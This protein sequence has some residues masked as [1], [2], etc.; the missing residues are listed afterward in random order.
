MA[1]RTTGLSC[2][3][4]GRVVL[5]DVNIAVPQGRITCVLG[6]SGC[7]KSTLLKTL[8]MLEPAMGGSIYIGADDMCCCDNARLQVLRRSVGVLFQG[9]ALFNS[10]TLLENVAFP[11]LELTELDEAIATETARLKLAL[12][13]LAPYAHFLPAEV[14]G[15]MRKRCGIAR[16]LVR[17]PA[18]LFLDEPGAGLDPTTSAGLD[19]MILGIRNRLGTTIVVVTHELPSIHAIADHCIMLAGGRVIAQGTLEQVGASGAPGVREFFERI[20]PD[21]PQPT[22]GLATLLLP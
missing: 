8:L 15:G 9:A 4:D 14:S 11:L 17:D 7:G 1:I 3:Y 12:V 6:G 22:E 13:G 21:E 20:P 18:I 16:A 10:L 5:Q 2:G 19:R